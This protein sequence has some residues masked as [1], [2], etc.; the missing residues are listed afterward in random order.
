MGVSADC[1]AGFAQ[2][3]KPSGTSGT[4]ACIAEAD[5]ASSSAVTAASGPCWSLGRRKFLP[6]QLRPAHRR[7]HRK[8]LSRV[9]M[10]S[11]AV[12]RS[13]QRNRCS[14]L[15]IH[16]LVSGRQALHGVPS[17]D[18]PVGLLCRMLDPAKSTYRRAPQRII[19][20]SEIGSNVRA[21]SKD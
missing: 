2:L 6:R 5:H 14:V 12:R 21:R 10:L 16:H 7:D 13:A 19:R 4:G 8:A 3:A 15:R 9:A 1:V 18:A 20:K 11:R 17:S